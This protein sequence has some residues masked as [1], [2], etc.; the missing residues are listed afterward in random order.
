MMM[1]RPWI[2]CLRWQYLLMCFCPF[3]WL[4]SSDFCE[5]WSSFDHMLLFTDT[6]QLICT[7]CCIKKW[8]ISCRCLQHVYYT[9]SENLYYISTAP[10]TLT[11]ILFR[12]SLPS[13]CCNKLKPVFVETVW[14]PDQSHPSDIYILSTTSWMTWQRL[15]NM[16]N[17]AKNINSLSSPDPISGISIIQ[18]WNHCWQQFT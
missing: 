14:L 15:F 7:G 3:S 16:N 9:R 18:E 4:R 6:T 11:E 12:V 5:Y 13:F 17:I 1:E 8:A 10:K 2:K